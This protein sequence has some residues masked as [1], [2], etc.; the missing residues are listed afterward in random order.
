EYMR[1]SGVM[2][3]S[4]AGA[5]TGG[6]LGLKTLIQRAG[7]VGA[8]SGAGSAAG[9]ATPKEAAIQTAAG[10][11]AQ[12]IAEGTTALLGAVKGMLPS[13]LRASA[14]STL[15]QVKDVAGNIP[16][17][18]GKFGDTALQL[19]QEGQSG[20]S[21]PRSVS[22]LVQRIT[23]PGSNPLTYAEAKSFQENISALSASERA[24]I[25]PNVKRL[26][27]QL[28]GELKSSLEDA[29]QLGGMQPGTF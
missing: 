28:N 26:L 19:W 16:V 8:G 3:G 6:G 29:S 13:S 1:Q 27:G 11:V 10:A 4:A 17:N 20:A 9:G 15:G 12:P 21:L 25:K 18:T 5:M 22:R 2:A 23:N 7:A 14:G 24:N